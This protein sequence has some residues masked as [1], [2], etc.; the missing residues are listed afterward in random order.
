M[1]RMS[2][3]SLKSKRNRAEEIFNILDQKYPGTGT[4]LTHDS[5]FQLLI[6]TILSAQC[7][8]ERVNK[9]T[10]SLFNDFPTPSKMAEA[11]LQQI[12]D[13][14]KSVNF[15]NNKAE[16]IK[17]TAHILVKNYHS[18]VPQSL[19]ELIKLPG[20]G[21]KTANV[22]L[23]Q[24]FGQPGITVDTH[25]NRVSRRLG[26]S[27]SK[28]PVKAEYE[29]MKVYPKEKWT[30]MSSIVILHGRNTCKAQKPLC[31]ECELAYLCPKI[32]V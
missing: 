6:A 29:L 31:G 16:N 4:F 7:T 15:F 14:I 17:E 22:V 13:K 28:D 2:K 30:P 1:S 21:R 27:T 18:E 5:P 3:E 25:V 32:D 9:V 26:L 24:A 8:D 20:V 10:P 11:P 23:G 12:K 19:S